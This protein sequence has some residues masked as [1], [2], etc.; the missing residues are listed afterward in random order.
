MD[1]PANSSVMG[2]K[3]ICIL[4]VLDD[5]TCH[6]IVSDMLHNQTYQ[7]IFFYLHIYMYLEV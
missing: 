4:L 6:N 3:N 7:G 5:F 2:T 1:I